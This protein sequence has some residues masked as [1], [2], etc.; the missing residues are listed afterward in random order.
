MKSDLMGSPSRDMFKHWHKQRP[1]PNSFYACDVDFVLIEFNP[2]HIAAIL[3]YKMP[4]DKLTSTECL[5]FNELSKHY[6]VYIV[7]SNADFINFTI[8]RYAGCDLSI[9]PIQPCL[10]DKLLLHRQVEFIKW[11]ANIRRQA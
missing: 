3:D 4:K 1:M 10:A 7:Y 6:P 8:F 11:E 9:E 5:A 2:P